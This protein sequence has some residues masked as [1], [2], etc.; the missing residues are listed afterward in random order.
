MKGIVSL[1]VI[2]ALAF[3]A[4]HFRDEIKDVFS[5]GEAKDVSD[6]GASDRAKPDAVGP[7]PEPP[8]PPKRPEIDPDIVEKFPLPE[9]ETL[10]ELV[11]N[12]RNIPP[13]AFPRAIVAERPV[14]VILGG[15]VG[16][17]TLP[18]GREITAIGITGEMLT[19]ISKNVGPDGALL[20][21]ASAPTGTIGIDET[22]F[23]EVLGGIY[24]AWKK[25]KTNAVLTQRKT[26]MREREDAAV[27]ANT[28]TGPTP[29]DPDPDPVSRPATPTSIDPKVG[30]RPEKSPDGTV[31][32]MVASIKARDVTEIKLD[33][34]D[35]WGRIRYEVIDGEPY[36]TGTVTYKTATLFGIIDSEAMA[37]IRKGKVID[38]IY[39]GSGEEVP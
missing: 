32:V 18:E 31:P 7:L 3:A 25:R 30:P 19:V 36:W 20:V 39:T 16:K 24:E 37:L 1:L 12:W 21:S 34:I 29:A 9:F 5:G 38:W 11:G 6:A 10:E 13:S 8:P 35:G 27:A 26:A 14:D 22:N 23:K 2:A 4:W 33:E 28:S 15:G 17:R